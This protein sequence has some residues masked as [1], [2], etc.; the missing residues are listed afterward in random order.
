MAVESRYDKLLALVDWY[1]TTDAADPFYINAPQFQA[2]VVGT[3]V[4]D[5][6][7]KTCRTQD[8]DNL[9]VAANFNAEK[10]TLKAKLGPGNVRAARPVQLAAAP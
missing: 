1:A 2:M 5:E 4:V 7:S 9:F 6:G 8:M 3:K 10:G